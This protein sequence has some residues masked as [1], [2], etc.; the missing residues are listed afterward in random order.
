MDYRALHG[1]IWYELAFLQ[2]VVSMKWHALKL[3]CD[4]N[5]IKIDSSFKYNVIFGASGA[6][7]LTASEKKEISPKKWEGRDLSLNRI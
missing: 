3:I 5:S 6:H 7:S 1:I 4:A 2:I